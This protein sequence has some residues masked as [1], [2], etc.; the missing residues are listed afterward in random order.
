MYNV[1]EINKFPNIFE[2][3]NIIVPYNWMF[4]QKKSNLFYDLQWIHGE[5]K[6]LK[7]LY[8]SLCLTFKM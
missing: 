4:I 7:S 2:W 3:H 8:H 5:K 6:N 1:P